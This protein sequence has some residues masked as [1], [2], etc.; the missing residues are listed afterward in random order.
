VGSLRKRLY[1]STR[2]V[3]LNRAIQKDGMHAFEQV[4]DSAVASTI[5][6]SSEGSVISPFPTIAPSIF[7]ADPAFVTP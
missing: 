3:F 4:A 5:F 2:L 6:S 7:T 1:E